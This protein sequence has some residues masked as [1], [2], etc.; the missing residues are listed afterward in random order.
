V[1]GT[2]QLQEPLPDLTGHIQ[3]DRVTLFQLFQSQS[4]IHYFQEISCATRRSKLEAGTWPPS[5]Q[6]TSHPSPGFSQA[7]RHAVFSSTSHSPR[8]VAPGGPLLIFHRTPVCKVNASAY[9]GAGVFYA[10]T[11]Y[12]DIIL[13]NLSNWLQILTASM[14]N[15]GGQ[16]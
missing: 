6:P 1:L 5:L 9:S 7:K 14:Y 15:R 11:A 13:H 12:L 8:R 2:A 3:A 10:I 4:A 16:Q